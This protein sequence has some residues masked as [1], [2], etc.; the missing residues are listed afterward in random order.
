MG[1]IETLEK[2]KKQHIFVVMLIVIA[3]PLLFP[4]LFKQPIIVT[5]LTE[6]FYDQLQLLEPGDYVVISAVVHVALFPETMAIIPICK[7]LITRGIKILVTNFGSYPEGPLLFTSF[8]EPELEAIGGVY[9][10]DYVNFGV[11]GGQL[12]ATMASMTFAKDPRN[13][14]HVDWYN[15]P[16]NELSILTPLFDEMDASG[17]AF[18]TLSQIK[19]CMDWGVGIGPVLTT[20]VIPYKKTAVS[21][22]TTLAA[23]L[24]MPLFSAKLIK[25]LLYGTRGGA[26]IE[27]LFGE[28]GTSNAYVSAMSLQHTAFFVFI[29]IGNIIYFGKKRKGGQ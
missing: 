10:E 9:G 13:L 11:M 24:F 28:V 7:D 1:L 21:V 26:E 4:S 25:G 23:M 17:D 8:V 18:I 22:T 19:L 6:A 14:V 27:I 15:N 2:I 12:G 5:N 3:L 20:W 29:L 16:L